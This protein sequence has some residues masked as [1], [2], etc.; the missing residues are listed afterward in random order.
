M[1]GGSFR[2]QHTSVV[3]AN[4]CKGGGGEGEWVGGGNRI[5]PS[6]LLLFH[7]EKLKSSVGF[8]SKGIDGGRGL[9]GGA[10]K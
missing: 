8:P 2:R 3:L 1:G 4:G 7:G 9:G 5:K 6:Y 10:E